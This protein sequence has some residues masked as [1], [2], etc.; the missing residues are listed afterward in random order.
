[1]AEYEPE[2]SRNITGTAST[3]DGRWT[4]AAGKPPKGVPQK[5]PA[6][7]GEAAEDLSEETP[8]DGK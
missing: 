2:D 8:P 4:N 6:S 5:H 3:P 7:A 1:M